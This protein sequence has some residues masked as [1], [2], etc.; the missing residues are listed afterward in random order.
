[1]AIVEKTTPSGKTHY[2]VRVR[3]SFGGWFPAKTFHKQV[4]AEKYER[5]LEYQRDR[6]SL[7]ST[8][9]Q[10]NLTFEDYWNQW[11]AECRID[12]SEGWQLSQNQM[13]RDYILPHLGSKKLVEI[14]SQD[15]SRLFVL[16]KKNGMSEPMRLHIYRLLHKIFVDAVEEYEYLN[17]NPVR[18][19]HRAKPQKKERAFLTPNEARNLAN[20]VRNHWIGPAIWVGLF[21]GL[22]PCEI[23]ALTWDC[24]DFENKK[25]LI[26]SSY[27]RKV[28]RI[29]ASTKQK[30]WGEAP[31]PK[32]LL[33]YLQE[34]RE[35]S[36][37]GPFVAS[38]MKGGMLKYN[39]FLS[40]LEKFCKEVKVT[41]IT[42]HE[43]RHSCTELYMEAGASAEDVRR[44]LNQ[45]SLT[46]TWRYI[47]RTN[48]RLTGI[49][50]QVKNV[51][52][53]SVPPPEPPK[54]R[55]HLRL[56]S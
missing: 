34:I 10:R 33:D 41:R 11:A 56:V 12:V 4:D 45:S 24:V 3:D 32:P 50:E 48:D 14:C 17:H 51:T 54:S 36:K 7:S 26:R 2:L 39:I 43:L 1:M 31:M 5:D 44:L 40:N 37:R 19:K 25:I 23:Q 35:S 30:N 22:R 21:A 13:A 28:N 52:T 8:K 47:H 20:A 9:E 38:G 6:G 46:A 29:E 15:L 18:R 55:G 53:P 42:P 49:A 27:K 16:L